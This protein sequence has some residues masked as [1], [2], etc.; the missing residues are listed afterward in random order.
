MIKPHNL[1]TALKKHLS[2]RSAA[3][4]P[5]LTVKKVTDQDQLQELIITAYTEDSLTIEVVQALCTGAW[6]LKH[7]PLAEC[8]LQNDRVYYWDWLFV[9]ENDDLRLKIFQLC[10]DSSLAGH[11][12]TAKMLE[13]I[14][15]TY[16]WLNWTKHASQYLQNCSECRRAKPSWQ[17]Y[18]GAL[19]PLPVPECHWVDIFMDFMEGLPLSLNENSALCITMIVI[20]NC[21][22][23]QAHAILWS[24]TAVKDTAMVFYYWV[25]PHHGL[26][27]TIISD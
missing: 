17:R 7:F 10:H 27:F 8:T 23:K 13:L 15:W 21:L 9:P 20:V 26:P 19:K 22:S 12:G 18:Q 25:F 3:L 5:V 11:S 6:C 4:N 16:W 1:F 24:K 2:L 14:A